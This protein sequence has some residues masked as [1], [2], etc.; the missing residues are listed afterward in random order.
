MPMQG[1]NDF[2]QTQPQIPHMNP[3]NQVNYYDNQQPIAK[4]PNGQHDQFC[5]DPYSNNNFNNNLNNNQ[6]INN[7]SPNRQ[8]Y[9][10]NGNSTI[11]QGIPGNSII[12]QGNYNAVDGQDQQYNPNNLNYN[13]SNGANQNS[14]YITLHLL[15]YLFYYLYNIYLIFNIDLELSITYKNYEVDQENKKKERLDYGSYLKQQMDIK[16]CNYKTSNFDLNFNPN[17]LAIKEKQ[18]QKK[19]LDELEEERKLKREQ[20]EINRRYE[21]EKNK[22]KA[23]VDK[24]AADNK[25]FIIEKQQKKKNIV[26]FP[27]NP[28]NVQVTDNNT[29]YQNYDQQQEFNQ[30]IQQHDYNQYN[31]NPPQEQQN[32]F[33]EALIENELL[34]LRTNLMDQQNE[35]LRQINDLKMDAQKQNIER[36]EALQE[37]NTLKEELSKN[38][39]DEEVRKKYVYDVIVD[40]NNKVNEIYT[41]TRLPPIDE[42]N[43]KVDLLN[44]I[45][46]KLNNQ[47]YDNHLKYPNRIQKVPDLNELND[48][49]LKAESKFIDIDTYHVHNVILI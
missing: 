20:E 14:I 34:K 36:Y 30:P 37:I 2:H 29:N 24:I 17:Y 39:V 18:K 3:S 15:I 13:N 40:N 49:Y 12:N 28:V 33:S 46:K 43:M 7:N 10:D 38:R 27:E 6:M 41:S 47:M 4:T 42:N 44:P 23:K 48:K 16:N 19:K 35:L 21:E 31:Q 11:N 8:P 45:N 26:E 25:N 5:N 32:P 9:F 1:N 22:E